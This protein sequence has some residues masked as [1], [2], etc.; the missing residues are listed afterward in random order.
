MANSV[1]VGI[2]V[3]VTEGDGLELGEEAETTPVSP[4]LEEV[5]A[6]SVP[7]FPEQAAITSRM[8]AITPVLPIQ[9]MSPLH[10]WLD[11]RITK[12]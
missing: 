7:R 3:N 6:L 1:C 9:R 11:T 4:S 5:D 10:E 12:D 8:L 2:G